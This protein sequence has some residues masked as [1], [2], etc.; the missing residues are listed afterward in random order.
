MGQ[1]LQPLREGL[2][3]ILGETEQ[4]RRQRLREE[5]PCRSF[6]DSY[7]KCMEEHHNQRPRPY[8]VE[9]CDDVRSTYLECRTKQKKAAAAE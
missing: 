5:D 6:L 2:S 4:Q 3:G 1:E 9:W 7:V 8:E